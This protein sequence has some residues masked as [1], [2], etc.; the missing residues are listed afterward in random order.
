MTTIQGWPSTIKEVSGVLQPYWTFR[1][2]LMTEDGIVLKGTWIVVPTVV[3][4]P[5]P[6]GGGSCTGPMAAV[7]R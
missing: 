2:E 6:L 1:E 4:L 5:L 7:D 3:D